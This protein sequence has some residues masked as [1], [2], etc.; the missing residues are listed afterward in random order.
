ML[1]WSDERLLAVAVVYRVRAAYV[2]TM[3]RV[4]AF[5]LTATLGLHAAEARA[6]HHEQRNWGLLGAGG[7]A[8][9]VG[10][11]GSFWG[12]S[13]AQETNGRPLSGITSAGAAVV[14]GCIAGAWPIER[15]QPQAALWSP[16]QPLTVHW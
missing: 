14:V 4:G 11:G 1:L 7:I 3:T 15:A 2:C 13:I 5:L 16:E 12:V 9:S 8:T 10:V 6:D